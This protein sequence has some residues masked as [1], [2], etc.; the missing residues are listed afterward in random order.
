MS[1]DESAENGFSLNGIPMAGRTYWNLG[2]ASLY[3]EALR[4]N[5]GIVAESGPLV[6]CTVSAYRALSE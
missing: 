3:E 6:C 4:R 5:E 1:F 2:T